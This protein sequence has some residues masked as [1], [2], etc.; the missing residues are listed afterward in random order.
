MILLLMLMSEITGRGGRMPIK[1][2]VCDNSKAYAI[3][4]E[5]FDTGKHTRFMCRECGTRFN[6]FVKTTVDIDISSIRKGKG[7]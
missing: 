3:K 1:C 4:S 5:K 6:G 7:R 2:P